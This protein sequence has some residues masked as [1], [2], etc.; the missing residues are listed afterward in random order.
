MRKS[1]LERTHR[2]STNEQREKA[3]RKAS[4]SSFLPLAY[5]I[6]SIIFPG[7]VK[8]HKQLVKTHAKTTTTMRISFR[9][10]APTPVS[11]ILYKLQ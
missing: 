11:T 5:Q 8:L 4:G 1:S 10:K 3:Q 6:K 7:D 9:E 2:Q